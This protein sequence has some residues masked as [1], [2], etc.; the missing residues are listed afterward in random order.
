MAGNISTRAGDKGKTGVGGGGRVDKDDARIECLGD[1]DEAN[2]S[3]GLLRS[4][5]PA[6]HPWEDG[7]RRIQTEMMNLMAHVATPS[8]VD[9]RPA[10]P[11]PTES[12]IWMEGWMKQIEDELAS[13]T[14]YFLLPGGNEVCALCHM[15]RTIS[16]RAERR[17]VTL[18]KADP[19][20]PSVMQFVNRLSDLLFKLS[21]EESHKQGLTEDR[22]RLFR[23]NRK[24]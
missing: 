3:L 24:K 15:A 6:D 19:V 9:P 10:S 20:D 18:N 5:L 22:W 14:E 23:P 21:R 17:L 1:L 12:S 7:L 11:L 13:V 4:K 16:R 2:S 8:E